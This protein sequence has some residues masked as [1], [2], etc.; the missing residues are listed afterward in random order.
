[1]CLEGCH[2]Y[3]CTRGEGQCECGGGG[4]GGMQD[5]PHPGFAAPRRQKGGAWWLVREVCCHPSQE[6]H[7]PLVEVQI[8]IIATDEKAT[9]AE[10]PPPL[11]HINLNPL[12]H[13]RR[14]IIV[15]PLPPN[16]G[17]SN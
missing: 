8:V 14:P 10:Q 17:L 2:T 15:F 16:G 4:G 13:Q 12:W 11:H 3:M 7:A 1:M 9:A 5:N 6:L